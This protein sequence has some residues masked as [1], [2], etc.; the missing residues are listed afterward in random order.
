MLKYEYNDTI[1][2]LEIEPKYLQEGLSYARV[3]GCSKI[4]L[5]NLLG[6]SSL[7]SNGELKADFSFFKDG[8]FV[9]DLMISEDVKIDNLD[10]IYYLKELVFLSCEQKLPLNFSFLKNLETLY[11][12]YDKRFVG[13]NSLKKLKNVLVN[14]L[15]ENDCRIF[16]GMST[17]LKLRLTGNFITLNGIEDIKNLN[18]L[19]VSYS[20]KLIDMNNINELDYLSSLHVEKCKGI[21][22]FSFLSENKSIKN[23]FLSEVDSVDFVKNMGSLEDISF[24][25][26]KN[27]NLEPLLNCNSLRKVYFYPDKKNY[28]YKLKDFLILLNSH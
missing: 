25:N 16:T 5:K 9:T 12:K 7:K 19:K 27:G 26:L 28:N 21:S 13:F 18:D 23:L 11:I 22:D 6:N 10:G 14:S 15:N 3:K 20:P 2:F 24:W 17:I 8:F 1:E 4:R